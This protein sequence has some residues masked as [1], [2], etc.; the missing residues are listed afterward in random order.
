MK[1]ELSVVLK[2]LPKPDINLLQISPLLGLNLTEI[3]AI[4]K[5]LKSSIKYVY[6]F[7]MC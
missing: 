3:M 6:S 7:Q 4:R 5:T 1:R 2:I